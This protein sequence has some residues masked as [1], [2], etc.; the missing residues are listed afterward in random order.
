M[1][2]GAA[3][4]N[5]QYYRTKWKSIANVLWNS[6]LGVSKIAVAGSRAIGKQRLDSDMDVIFSVTGDP[7][8]QEFYPKLIN[9]MKSNFPNENV[10]PG[11]EYNVVHLNFQSGGKFEL[12]LRT[13]SQFNR[14][15]QEDV[16]Y[17]RKNL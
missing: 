7:S 9:L 3:Q 10:Y 15:H 5:D 2:N 11:S 16:D 1:T 8:K 13:E 12:V 14:E 6:N 17:R 4:H